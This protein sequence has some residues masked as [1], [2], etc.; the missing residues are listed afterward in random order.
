M[1]FGWHKKR[2]AE[3]P[4]P[5]GAVIRLVRR[6]DVKA[7][8]AITAEAFDGISSEQNVE[9]VFGKVAGTTWQE[10]RCTYIERDV[11]YW[12][13]TCYVAERDGRVIG[14]LT[15]VADTATRTGHIRNMAVAPAFQGQ[16]LGRALIEH[17][18]DAFRAAGMRYARIE[19]LEQ[20]TRCTEFYPRL[21]F[22]EIARQVMYFRELD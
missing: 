9:R 11:E 4:A 16:G 20:N 7:L 8:R 2:V 5:A 1:M 14:Y 17:A 21:G 12:P 13:S 18:L 3:K 22:T 15:S 6:G 19:A 10:R